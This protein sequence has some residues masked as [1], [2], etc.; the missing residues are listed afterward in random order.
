MHSSQDSGFG[1]NPQKLQGG[2]VLQQCKPPARARESV[3][4][5]DR[6]ANS[7]RAN[8]SLT[9]KVFRVSGQASKESLLAGAVENL[10]AEKDAKLKE[11]APMKK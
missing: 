5:N 1:L 7:P 10:K 4:M 3:V 11:L 8:Q 9:G 6:K 2:E